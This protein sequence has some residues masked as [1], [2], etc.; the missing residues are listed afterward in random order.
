MKIIIIGASGRIGSKVKEALLVKGHEVI[1]VGS[2][3][4]DIV[5]DYTNEQSVYEMFGQAGEFDALISVAGGD[6]RFKRYAD[7]TDDD[8]LFGF[9]RKFLSQVRLVR[10]GEGCA[11]DNA[12]FTLTSG[13]LS[14]YPNEASIA[15]GPLNS[16]VDTFVSNAAPVMPRNIRLNVVS[17]APIVEPGHERK[18]LVTA[19]QTAERY[20]DALEGSFTGKV[21][22]VWG[23][24]PHSFD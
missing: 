15:T 19:A 5:A 13:F 12:S 4:G 1:R 16:M 24:L 6:S 22:R 14:H 20:V 17:P 2:R 18:G 7:L 9:E 8:F 10:L 11:R 21:L 23:G 3:S